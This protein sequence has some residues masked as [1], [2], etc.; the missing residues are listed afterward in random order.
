M[1]D[2]KIDTIGGQKKSEKETHNKINE[3]V[4]GVRWKFKQKTSGGKVK[5]LT[6]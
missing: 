4:K 2:E 6:T 5:V 1:R 3:H